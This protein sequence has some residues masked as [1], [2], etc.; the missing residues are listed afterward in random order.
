MKQHT[1]NAKAM[2]HTQL[3]GSIDMD[4]RQWVD[5]VL[6]ITAQTVYAEPQGYWFYFYNLNYSCENTFPKYV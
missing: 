4:T 5:G 6:S 1:I 2:L 3:L